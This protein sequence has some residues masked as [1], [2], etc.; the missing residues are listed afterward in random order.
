MTETSIL[1]EEALAVLQS[2]SHLFRFHPDDADL[3][4]YKALLIPSLLGT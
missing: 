2:Y 4:E 1:L 3:S